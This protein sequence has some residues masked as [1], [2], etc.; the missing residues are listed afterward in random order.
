MDL[1]T[2]FKIAQFILQQHSY[3]FG[4]RNI[5]QNRVNGLFGVVPGDSTSDVCE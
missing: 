4:G 5:I 3:L 1:K 2:H